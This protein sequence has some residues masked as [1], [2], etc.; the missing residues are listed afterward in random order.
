MRWPE[1]AYRFVEEEARAQ[2]IPT[3]QLVR[4]GAIAWAAYCAG[5]RSTDPGR[6]MLAI[7]ERLRR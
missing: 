5:Q 1:H 6:T 3:S 7:I 2:G 4:E